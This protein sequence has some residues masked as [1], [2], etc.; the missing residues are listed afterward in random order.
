[1]TRMHLTVI[2]L[3]IASSLI[4]VDKPDFAADS[5][6]LMNGGTESY[7]KKYESLRDDGVPDW[8]GKVPQALEAGNP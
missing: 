7:G 8:L 6:S 5:T 1:M 4:A 3:L 2:I